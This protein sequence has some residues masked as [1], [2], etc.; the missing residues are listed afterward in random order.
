MHKIDDRVKINEP[1]NLDHNK[2]ATVRAIDFT[3]GNP[4]QAHVDGDEYAF[5]YKESMLTPVNESAVNEAVSDL[6]SG[7]GIGGLARHVEEMPVPSLAAMKRVE[8]LESEATT[9]RKCGDDDAF[10][11]AMFTTDPAS[12]SCDDCYG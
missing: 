10:D 2:L 8:K 12:G 4:Y 5:W 1:R 6:D 3:N 11:G 7:L 9:C